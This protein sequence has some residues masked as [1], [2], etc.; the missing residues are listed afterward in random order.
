MLA[1]DL[2]CAA[3]GPD[4]DAPGLA[5]GLMGCLLLIIGAAL[6]GFFGFKAPASESWLI[7]AGFVVLWAGFSWPEE[8]K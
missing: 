3:S 7:L 6:L 2:G 4:H 8:K 1:S 5:V